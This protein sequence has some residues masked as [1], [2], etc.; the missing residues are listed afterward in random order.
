M[1]TNSYWAIVLTAFAVFLFLETANANVTAASNN[2]P[3]KHRAQTKAIL[4]AQYATYPTYPTNP[5][6]ST[7]STFGAASAQRFLEERAEE[8]RIDGEADGSS[9]L[10]LLYGR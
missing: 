3:D 4:V 7:D 8:G 9:G 2:P 10:L 6:Y 1:Y 5:T